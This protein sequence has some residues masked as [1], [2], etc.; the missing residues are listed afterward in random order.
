MK[1]FL[2]F[3]V[4]SA[5]MLSS[6]NNQDQSTQPTEYDNSRFYSL[7]PNNSTEF[8]TAEQIGQ[9]L[10]QPNS[11]GLIRLLKTEYDACGWVGS[12]ANLTYDPIE[13]DDSYLTDAVFWSNRSQVNIGDHFEINAESIKQYGNGT[14]YTALGGSH[15]AVINFGDQ[16]NKFKF[17]DNSLFPGFRDSLSF[18]SPIH[19]TNLNRLDTVYSNQ[20]LVINWTG[21]SLSGKV[22]ISII[23]SRLQDNY[24]PNGE[25]TGINLYMNPNSNG[26]LPQITH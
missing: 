2:I 18:Q 26:T 19:I 13:Y 8:F 4:A 7:V 16:L 21:G 6:C 3:I 12:G 20:D 10:N 23:A 22:Q 5:M 14:T 17:Y 1:I 9:Y 24:I 25:T 11:I 15:F